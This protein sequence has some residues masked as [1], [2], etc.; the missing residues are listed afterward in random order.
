MKLWLCNFLLLPV[1]APP[2]SSKYSPQHPVLKYLTIFVLRFSFTKMDRLT[3]KQ[4]QLYVHLLWSECC[5][6]KIVFTL[7]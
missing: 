6:H 4:T 3:G 5:E 1:T 7:I 2:L